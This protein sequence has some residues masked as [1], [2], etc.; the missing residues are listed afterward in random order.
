MKIDILGVN[1]TDVVLVECKSRLSQGDVEEF[2]SILPPS[3]WLL[4]LH[5]ITPLGKA[6]VYT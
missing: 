5:A 4:G 2:L 3:T 1:S 6:T